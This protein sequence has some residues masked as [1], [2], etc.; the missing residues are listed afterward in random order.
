MD[1]WRRK[2]AVLSLMMPN[3]RERGERERRERRREREREREKERDH[4]HAK[5]LHRRGKKCQL[6]QLL[7]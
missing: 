7:R 1:G 5:E 6:Q 3:K 2:R 4:L